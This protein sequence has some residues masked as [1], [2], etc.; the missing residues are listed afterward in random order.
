MCVK[1]QFSISDISRDI[2]GVRNFTLGHKIFTQTS[3][4]FWGQS[5]QAFSVDKGGSS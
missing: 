5:S 1:F 4:S 2:K 3:P